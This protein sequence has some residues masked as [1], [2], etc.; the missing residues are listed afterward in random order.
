MFQSNESLREVAEGLQ[1]SV[2]ELKAGR[3][4]GLI[5][6]NHASQRMQEHH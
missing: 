1:I 2:I 5:W 6:D 4:P 3:S